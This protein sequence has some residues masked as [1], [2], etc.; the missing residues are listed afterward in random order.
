PG[1][2]Q[3][4]LVPGQNAAGDGQATLG[5]RS[6]YG[7]SRT[8]HVVL[9][10]GSVAVS[11]WDFRLGTGQTWQRTLSEPAGQRLTAELT[12]SQRAAPQTVTITSS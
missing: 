9:R 3:L 1:F 7:G 5:V 2:A 4:W 12:A 6:G 8:F 11:S 10:R